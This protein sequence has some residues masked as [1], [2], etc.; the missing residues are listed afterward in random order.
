MTRAIVNP[1]QFGVSFSLKQCRDFDIDPAETLGW[2]INKAGFRR[3]RLMSYWNE[4]EKQPG[5][6]DFKELD[7]QVA[8]ISKAQGVITLSLG[9]RQ[10]R[11]PENHWPEWAWQ[12][13]K[14]E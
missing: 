6:Y 11:W 9:A 5:S 7:R 4:H 10:P 1:E 2:L 8:A 13:P 14:A 12:L 3:F